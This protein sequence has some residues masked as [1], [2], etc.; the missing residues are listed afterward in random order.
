MDK[1]GLK[2]MLT[3]EMIESLLT[4][5]GSASPI[6]S[7][8]S[9]IY[10]TVCH[11]GHSHKLYYY[12]ES[13][14]FYCYTECNENLDIYLLVERYAKQMFNEDWSFPKCIKYVGDFFNIEVGNGDIDTTRG[15]GEKVEEELVDDLDWLNKFK[16]RKKE[17]KELEIYDDV[18]LNTFLYKHHTNF[19]NEGISPET[20][21]KYGITYN[22]HDGRIVIPH[23][24][25]NGELV[26]IRGR[27]TAATPNADRAK[28]L[29]IF[30][31]GHMY[32]HD[33]GKNLYGL[34]RTK[35]AIQALKKVVIWEGEK[36]VLKCDTFYGD[37]NYTVASCGRVISDKQRD[38]LL[39]LGVNEVIIGYD[40]QF[41]YDWYGQWTPEMTKYA[42]YLKR[43]AKKFLPYV[44]V[45]L[46]WDSKEYLDYKDAPCDKGQAILEMMLK[47]RIEINDY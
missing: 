8:D 25:I 5:M 7:G 10:Q 31:N 13:N 22:H 29:P 17:D 42:E 40:K 47:E 44:S 28:Y 36:S 38:L 39:G 18:V 34:E 14:S 15:F 33:T 4:K 24:N 3:P 46:L 37:R 1:D 16:P 41:E 43:I 12:T 32:K 26:G 30:Q 23:R 45:K 35:Y 2:E 21:D 11:G 9:Y 20:M 27:A 19:L 6:K